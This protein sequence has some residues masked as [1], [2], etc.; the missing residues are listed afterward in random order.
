MYHQFASFDRGNDITANATVVSREIGGGAC[1]VPFENGE[2][3]ITLDLTD[4][5]TTQIITITRKLPF[6]FTTS[7]LSFRAM[8]TTLCA[9]PTQPCT[10]STIASKRTW[11]ISSHFVF[12]II[13]MFTFI[14][15]RHAFSWM[16][17]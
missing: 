16:C 8:L 4:L 13:F 2:K 1:C 10:V 7:S 9:M 11:S 6:F 17:N 3:Q 5:T 14:F 15:L 12:M